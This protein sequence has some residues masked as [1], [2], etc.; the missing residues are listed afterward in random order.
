MI[1]EGKKTIISSNRSENHKENHPNKERKF[2][3]AQL[4]LIFIQLHFTF[5]H[6]AV[7]A[8]RLTLFSCDHS[9]GLI[10]CPGRAIGI[11]SRLI[12]T[13]TICL[14][15]W[16]GLMEHEKHNSLILCTRESGEDLL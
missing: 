10:C 5:N 8:V 4:R 1:C 16:E 3:P 14:C 12:S 9:I 7:I 6:Q 2:Y 11:Y 13:H 15:M